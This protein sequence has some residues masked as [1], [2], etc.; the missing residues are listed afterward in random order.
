MKYATCYN[1]LVKHFQDEKFYG[2]ATVGEK[3]QAV[4]PAAARKAMNLKKGDKLLIFGVGGMLMCAKLANLQKFA[5]D[6]AQKA[7]KIRSLITK[8]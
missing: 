3:G 2:T 6:L 5:T 7:A 8:I 1:S 4:I